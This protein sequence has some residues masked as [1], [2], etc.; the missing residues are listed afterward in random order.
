MGQISL[1][2][3]RNLQGFWVCSAN[4]KHWQLWLKG[5]KR[6]RNERKL[7]DSQNCTGRKQED[8]LFSC[9][10][11]ILHTKGR[12]SLRAKSLKTKRQNLGPQRITPRLWNLCCLLSYIF[13]LTF[14][15]FFWMGMLMTGTLCL[16][17]YCI[18]EQITCFLNS[19]IHRCR[20]ILPQD[21]SDLIHTWFRW[22]KWPDLGILSWWD[23]GFKLMLLM[24][25]DFWR[26]WNE[27]NAFYMWDW[28]EFLCTGGQTVIDRKMAP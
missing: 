2:Y 22:F 1:T 9:K 10:R 4:T 12:L 27:V 19:R 5:T 28:C 15:P 7:S 18:L 26:C 21:R 20:G 17:Q 13:N 3:T 11:V 24:G 25:W 6:V 23:F 8:Q 16:T 14:L